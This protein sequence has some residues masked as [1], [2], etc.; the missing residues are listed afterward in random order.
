VVEDS[1]NGVLAAR[2]A[3][4]RVVLVPNTSVPPGPGAVEAAD[5]VLARLGDLPLARPGAAA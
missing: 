4:M 3:G 2:A 5:A 1:R